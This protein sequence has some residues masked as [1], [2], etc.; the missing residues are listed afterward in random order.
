MV[1]WNAFV[2]RF[3]SPTGVFRHALHGNDAEDPS[4]KQYEIMYPAIARYFHT[5]FSNGVK[6]MQL[7]LDKSGTDRLLSG[8]LYSFDGA[9]ATLTS[10]YDSGSHVSSPCGERARGGPKN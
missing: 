7:T 9:R 5:H 1:Y 3:F 4:D 10:W 2:S 8:E 6:S